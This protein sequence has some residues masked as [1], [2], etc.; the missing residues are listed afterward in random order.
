METEREKRKG[1][2]APKAVLKDES[3][4]RRGFCSVFRWVYLGFL[5][6]LAEYISIYIYIHM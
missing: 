6:N 5:R 4:G 1:N 2:W 3:I